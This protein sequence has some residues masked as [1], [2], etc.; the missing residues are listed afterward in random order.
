MVQGEIEYT[1][2]LILFQNIPEINI[3]NI[4]IA[5]A[6]HR[7][8]T[9][10]FSIKYIQREYILYIYITNADNVIFGFSPIQPGEYI[11]PVDLTHVTGVILSFR[12]LRSNQKYHTFLC[13]TNKCS[14]NYKS[15]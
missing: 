3:I 1:Q 15:F 8:S 7:M 11:F 2:R 9:V 14:L 4:K 10:V 6:Y 12:V 5:F 13:E